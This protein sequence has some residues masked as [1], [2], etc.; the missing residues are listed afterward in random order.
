MFDFDVVTGPSPALR[1]ATEQGKSGRPRGAAAT[2]APPAAEATEPVRA[3][4]PPRPLPS[5]AAAQFSKP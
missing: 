5:G 4:A 1:A 2:V 3:D